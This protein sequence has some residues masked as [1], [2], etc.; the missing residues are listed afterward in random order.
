[1]SLFSQGPQPPT[2]I[3]YD[4][5]NVGSSLMDLPV[6]IFWGQRRLSTNAIWYGD[7]KHH[8]VNGKGK[9]GGAKA[10]QA[11]DYTAATILALCEGPLDSV[12]RAWAAG[13]TTTTSS[14]SQLNMT[15]FL[16]TAS[17]APWS[18]MESNYPDQARAYAL[19]AYLG[20]P[21][22]DL[23]ESATI[24]D[25]AF[26]CVRANGFAY[27]HTTPGWIDPNSHDQASA[28]DVLLSDCIRDLLTNVQYGALMAAADLG[29]MSQ[30]AAY[31]QAQG[32]FHSPLLTSLE[33]ANSVLDRWA[34]LSNSWMPP[35]APMARPTRPRPT[36]PTT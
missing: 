14:L 5:L 35:S 10:Q 13:S 33:K 9:G 12:A 18:W 7:F 3:R 4:S 36:S 17:Q 15:L 2:P 6:V 21:N 22:Q 25:N 30:Y 29:D 19:T 27:T 31:L 11:Y 23:G 28:I 20:C 26:E 1:M 8:P 34:Q 32:L 24:P 16:G